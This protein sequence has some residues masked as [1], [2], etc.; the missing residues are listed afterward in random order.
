MCGTRRV[1]ARNLVTWIRS[2]YSLVNDH[3]YKALLLI[4]MD[5]E[6]ENR[7][8]HA[9]GGTKKDGKIVVCQLN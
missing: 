5:F 2:N 6:K 1:L 9:A 7:S 3:E 8:N 4:E